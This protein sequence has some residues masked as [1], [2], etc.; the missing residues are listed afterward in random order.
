MQDNCSLFD[1]HLEM[2][3]KPS[4]CPTRHIWHV[5]H[6]TRLDASTCKR[7][8]VHTMLGFELNAANFSA[9]IIAEVA[10]Q[11]CDTWQK[12]GLLLICC[13]LAQS[14]F[15]EHKPPKASS[16]V[17]L[18]FAV[19]SPPLVFSVDRLFRITVSMN[20]TMWGIGNSRGSS[21]L[22]LLNSIFRVTF[23]AARGKKLLSSLL[24]P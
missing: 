7:C 10:C 16:P 19:L 24:Q 8:N 11:Q 13:M 18:V 2:H 23:T 22:C 21:R 14:S 17:L 1:V 9:A 12:I 20:G 15:A 5:K 4:S 6:N 3:D